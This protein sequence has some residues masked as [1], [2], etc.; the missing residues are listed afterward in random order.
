MRGQQTA[1][2]VASDVFELEF[3]GGIAEHHY[4][5]A[6]PGL[7]DLPWGTLAT[8]HYPPA[9]LEA[10]RRTWTEIAINEYRAVV[11]FTEVVSA[12]AAIRAP[13][14][15]LGMASEFILDEVSHVELASRMCMELGGAAPMAVDTAHM[16]AVP[17]DL[18]SQQRANEL[19]L[20]VSCVAEVYAGKTSVESMRSCKHPL[21]KAVHTRILQDESRHLRLGDLYFDWM[22]ESLDDAERKRLG[23]VLTKAI[24]GHERYLRRRIS[25]VRDG[26][27][28][29]GY[30]VDHIHEL[31]S[32]ESERFVPLAKK[33]MREDV[34]APLAR[35]GIV[36]EPGELDE[37]LR[38]NAS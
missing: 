30:S 7:E 32:L 8:G 35:R 36:P 10:A 38:E 28:E 9:L 27:T 3:L 24:F 11:A 29:E 34:L 17:P 37:L 4:R 6:R 5:R 20:R 15:L 2:T 13:I 22:S 12:L 16:Y 1:V 21:P 23:T 18:T 26:F 33:V 14:D 25:R 31:G 19:V